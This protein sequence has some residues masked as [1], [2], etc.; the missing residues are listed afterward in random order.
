MQQREEANIK[1][2][3]VVDKLGEAYLKTGF[4]LGTL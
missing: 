4:S 2:P 3:S 1:F